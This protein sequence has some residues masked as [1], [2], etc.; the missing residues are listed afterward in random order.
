MTQFA[1]ALADRAVLPELRFLEEHLCSGVKIYE[2]AGCVYGTCGG[3]EEEWDTDAIDRMAA[4][5][6]RV[7]IEW[8]GAGE[9][10]GFG[11]GQYYGEYLGSPHPGEGFSLA[12]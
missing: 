2:S 12:A 11:P 4:F 1:A 6:V 3:W 8:I 5:C 7:G 9:A 10:H